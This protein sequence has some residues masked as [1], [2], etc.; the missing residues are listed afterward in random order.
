[1]AMTRRKRRQL[2]ELPVRVCRYGERCLVCL[3]RIDA[4]EQYYDGAHGRRAHMS[5]AALVEEGKRREPS[6]Q[7]LNERKEGWAK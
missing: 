1:M 5:C 6:E 3:E 7:R 2:H 4:G